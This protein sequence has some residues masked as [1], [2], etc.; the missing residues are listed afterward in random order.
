MQ[1]KIMAECAHTWR[2]K[3]RLQE[4]MIIAKREIDAG[5]EIDLVYE[6]LEDEMDTRWR[7]VG[8]TKRQ[9]LEEIKKILANKYVLTV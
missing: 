7:F 6:I 5:E 9:Y 3:L 1:K 8:S 4:L 2:K